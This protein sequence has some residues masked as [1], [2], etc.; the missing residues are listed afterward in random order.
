MAS[1]FP[2]CPLNR[3]CH[4]KENPDRKKPPCLRKLPILAMTPLKNGQLFHRSCFNK[5][6][7][8]LFCFIEKIFSLL[9]VLI[10]FTPL[11]HLPQLVTDGLKDLTGN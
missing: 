11:S 7:G 5:F 3:E 10:F 4:V 1:T 8:H 6:S 2:C 9:G